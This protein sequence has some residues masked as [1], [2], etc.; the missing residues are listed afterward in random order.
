MSTSSTEFAN[1]VPADTTIPHRCT[2]A[3]DIPKLVAAPRRS[4]RHPLIRDERGRTDLPPIARPVRCSASVRDELTAAGIT[5]FRSTVP[6][7][8]PAS[9]VFAGH[10][11][12]TCRRVGVGR[13]RTGGSVPTR[14]VHHPHRHRRQPI[15]RPTGRLR[16]VTDDRRAVIG[17]APRRLHGEAT[18]ARP[19]TSPSLPQSGSTYSSAAIRSSLKATAGAAHRCPI[20]PR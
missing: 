1:R 16:H 3:V 2:A 13:R 6:G 10:R 9:P 8:H 15:E 20:M 18:A 19:A 17:I 11:A 12:G 7:R 14:R 5:T 4:G